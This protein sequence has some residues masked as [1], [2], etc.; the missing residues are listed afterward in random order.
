MALGLT[1]S[2]TENEYKEYF[3]GDKGGRCVG[4]TTLP[5]SC[6]TVKKSG[7]LKLLE[8]SGPVQA[9]NGV[10]LPLFDSTSLFYRFQ[11]LLRTVVWA[12]YSNTISE[13]TGINN[14]KVDVRK[15]QIVYTF[16]NVGVFPFYS[17]NI[18]MM[19]II[20]IIIIIIFINCNWAVTRWQWLFN[21]YTMIMT[22]LVE[23]CCWCVMDKYNCCIYK[24]GPR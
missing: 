18:L 6:A 1:R 13:S 3:L 19:M 22:I 16:V 11:P 15:K 23:T 24:G 7:S 17:C 10:A 2:L 21:M 12:A 14:Q 5:P 4:L 8:P 20:I 9:C